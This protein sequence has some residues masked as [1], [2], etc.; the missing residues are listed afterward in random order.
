ME[1]IK[2]MK[3]IWAVDREEG[4]KSWDK[5]IGQRLCYLVT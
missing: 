2:A 1:D 3:W 5:Y 4:Y